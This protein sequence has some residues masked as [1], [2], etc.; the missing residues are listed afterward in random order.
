MRLAR[1]PFLILAAALTLL[2]FGAGTASAVEVPAVIDG[3]PA[4][5]S[6]LGG[7]YR[8]DAGLKGFCPATAPDGCSMSVVVS[9]LVHPK[10]GA[11]KFMI[12]GSGSL[13]IAAGQS[14]QATAK[15]NLVGSHELRARGSFLANVA[16]IVASGGTQARSNGE[17]RFLIPPRVIDAETTLSKVDLAPGQRLVLRLTGE[18]PG[19]GY[20]WKFDPQDARSSLK[21]VANKSYPDPSC[22]PGAVGCFVIREVTYVP[23]GAGKATVSTGLYGPTPETDATVRITLAVTTHAPALEPKVVTVAAN[24]ARVVLAKD[25]ELVVRLAG[26]QGGFV[27]KPFAFTSAPNVQLIANT[28]IRLSCAA[29]LIGCGGERRLTYVNLRAGSTVI[30]MGLFG[31]GQ[32]APGR[33]FMVTVITR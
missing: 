7:S 25:Q 13:R 20:A 4:K 17:Q 27:W 1:R 30:Q 29:M 6:L 10:V 9:S 19:A 21:Q 26:E 31:P 12:V 23:K 3:G 14:L 2:A 8:L 18:N 16:V 15:V 24:N 11:P 5:S 22:A 32:T 28:P 33:R